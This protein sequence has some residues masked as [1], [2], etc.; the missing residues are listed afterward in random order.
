MACAGVTS[1][2]VCTQRPLSP[3]CLTCSC[4]GCSALRELPPALAGALPLRSLNLLH[5]G[6]A[7]LPLAPGCRRLGETGLEDDAGCSEVQRSTGA[8]GSTCSSGASA[9]S[10]YLSQLSELRWGVAEW[11]AAG[12]SPALR[13]W[14][15]PA[16]ALAA[17][18]VGPDLS[19]VAQASGLQVLQ[20]AHVPAGAEAQ[21]AEL[22]GRLPLLARLQVNSAILVG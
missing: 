4:E 19:P 20:L 1:R 18:V 3:C 6:V 5:S 11:E 8:A 2:R 16:G 12:G 21:L 9:S 15:T 17:S 13:R 22:R 14:A 7:H 10:T